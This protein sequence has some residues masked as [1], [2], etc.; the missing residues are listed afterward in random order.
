VQHSGPADELRHGRR[1]TGCLR[2]LDR[3]IPDTVDVLAG[4]PVACLGRP[5]KHE[6]R[7]PL[8]LQL[9]RASTLGLV[10]ELHGTSKLRIERNAAQTGQAHQVARYGTKRDQDQDAKGSLRIQRIEK[11]P[12]LDLVQD[13]RGDQPAIA[14]ARVPRARPTAGTR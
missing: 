2:Q 10:E 6:D 7:L 11:Y 13:R 3:E 4:R 12:G 1:G 8:R 14:P 5:G 9:G